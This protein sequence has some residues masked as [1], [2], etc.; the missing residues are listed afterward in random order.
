MKKS[1]FYFLAIIICV[2][3]IAQSPLPC[4]TGNCTTTTSMENCPSNGTNLVSSFKNAQLFISGASCSDGSCEGSVWHFTNITNAAGNIMNATVTIDAVE[5]AQLENIDDDAVV[6][7]SG[8]S[9]EFLFSPSI[10]SDI[11]LN[12]TDRK[13]YVQFTIRFF[14]AGVRDG[15]SLLTNL[16]YLNMISYDIDGNDAGNIS[17]GTAGSWYRESIYIKEMS[18]GNPSIKL[19]QATVLGKVN[20]TGPGSQWLGSQGSLCESPGISK[21]SQFTMGSLFSN[22]QHSISFRLG[23][24]YNAGGNIGRPS[25][26]YGIKL[27]CFNFLSEIHLPVN[28]YGF[29]A[30]RDGATARLDWITT[31]EQLNQ[32]FRV[33]RKTGNEDFENVGFLPSL[34]PDGNSQINL[35]YRFIDPNTSK[36]ITQYRIVQ[37]DLQEKVR[38]SEIRSVTG[39]GQANNKVI[40]FPNPSSNGKINIVFD[41]S[42]AGKDI[43]INEFTGRIVKSWKQASGNTVVAENLLPG[44][45]TVK[46]QDRGTSETNILKFIIG[47]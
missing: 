14:K 6:D 42:R 20:F 22:P 5:N 36:G 41:D 11:N 10:K 9:A 37:T 2:N 32:G 27:S 47:Q 15:Y 16:S 17:T 34:A 26:Q 44:I 12:G 35:S 46:I 24:D 18:D 40:V 1:I 28:L 3:T 8:I 13:G 19:D 38:V 4:N 33:Q 31:Y 30:K 39:M 43:I 25:S 23:Y 29:T 45:Y 7:Q 21:C